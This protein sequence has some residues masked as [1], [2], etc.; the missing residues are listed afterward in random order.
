MPTRNRKN[1]CDRFISLHFEKHLLWM[2]EHDRLT[3]STCHVLV[4]LW[5]N[6]KLYSVSQFNHFAAEQWTKCDQIIRKNLMLKRVQFKP[7]WTRTICHWIDC[8]NVRI[9]QIVQCSMF[10]LLTLVIFQYRHEIGVCVCA[11]VC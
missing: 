3:I 9:K 11:F 5:H 10:S 4:A 1:E 7:L 2:S 6:L 8:L